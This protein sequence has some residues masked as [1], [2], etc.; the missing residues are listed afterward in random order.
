MAFKID[1]FRSQNNKDFGYLRANKFKVM[2]TTPELLFNLPNAV[3]IAR[4]MEFYVQDAILPG[5]QLMTG[6]VRRW[7]YGPNE[8]R[9]FSPNFQQV[10]LTINI[11]GNMNTIK[12]FNGWLETI[13]PHDTRN[14]FFDQ[15]DLT[16]G[17]NY[18]LSYKSEYATDIQILLYAEDGK[19]MTTYT[20]KEAFP[21]NINQV[22]LSW[23]DTNQIAQMNVFIEY[24][25]W[26]KTD[27]PLQL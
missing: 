13:L 5:Y 4:N 14:A 11:D 2:I 3:E 24:L 15:S 16:G 6:N 20:L 9:P 7:G 1:D 8:S 10:Q 18:T 26:Y 19:L 23:G 17:D 12:Y 25:D 21:S 27:E 22:Q